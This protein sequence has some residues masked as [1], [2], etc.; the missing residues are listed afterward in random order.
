M[1]YVYAYIRKNDGS[2]Y[3]IGKGKGN[4]AYNKHAGVGVPKNKN[5]I[6]FLEKNLT[7]IGAFALERRYIEW[8]GRKDEG[9]GLLLNRT[10]G[11][12]GGSGTLQSVETRRKRAESMKGKNKIDKR[13]PEGKQRH[14]DKILGTKQTNEAN[15]KRSQALKGKVK[16][17]EHQD[18]I[19]AKL[20]NRPVVVHTCNVCCKTGKGMVM[21]RHHFENC[22]GVNNGA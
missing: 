20:K 3:Y 7:E 5:F 2:P 17:K 22:K 15:A 16:S 12:E 14:R 6:V 19:T 21:F 1:F 4:R 13:T 18:K 11:G 10:N 9:S 8:Y